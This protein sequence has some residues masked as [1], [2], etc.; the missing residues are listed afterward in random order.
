[1]VLKKT[2]DV[3][4]TQVKCSILYSIVYL[5]HKK[6]EYKRQRIKTAVYFLWVNIRDKTV[7][8]A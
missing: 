5:H 1:M 4:I 8:I 7:L 2:K 3:D 6:N